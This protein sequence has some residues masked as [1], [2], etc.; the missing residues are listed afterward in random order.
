MAMTACSAAQE[1]LN[2]REF[3][4]KRLDHMTHDIYATS[5]TYSMVTSASSSTRSDCE[6]Q[7]LK[8]ADIA[9]TSCS[10]ALVGQSR[11]SKGKGM[12]PRMVPRIGLKKTFIT[13]TKQFTTT[14][15]VCICNLCDGVNYK[16]EYRTRSVYIHSL[17]NANIV[18]SG[19]NMEIR[20]YL[21]KKV[22]RSVMIFTE[23]DVFFS[24]P[25]TPAG[26]R[27]G[28]HTWALLP[29]L[30]VHV[31]SQRIMYVCM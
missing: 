26:G 17:I 14:R 13:S 11:L 6:L 30:H 16:F 24:P 5:T 29:S 18:K 28:W 2:A 8:V 22:L 31:G 12:V 25:P 9:M 27:C 1:G 20:N 10:A 4:A 15:N 3:F 23:C 19:K 21:G 7:I